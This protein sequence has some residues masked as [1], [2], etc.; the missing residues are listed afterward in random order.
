M[1]KIEIP[2]NEL[3]FSF[4]RSSGPGGQNVN[5][6]NSKAVLHWNL[7]DSIALNY[8]S[9]IR[10]KNLFTNFINDEGFVVISSQEFRTQKSNI[11]SV[12]MKLKEMISRSQIIPKI[13]KKTKPKKGAVE[14]RLKTK[15]K[16]SDKKKE[17]EKNSFKMNHNLLRSI[18]IILT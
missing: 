6:V 1:L 3:N 5:K 14:D 16:D 18:Y 7:E 8:D 13:R 17:E 2:E 15:K 4:A 11:E 10:F 12:V 9:K